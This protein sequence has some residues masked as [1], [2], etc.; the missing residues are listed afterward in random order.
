MSAPC[1]LY[2]L[3][4][5]ADQ[6]LYVGITN[7][8]QRR[9]REHSRT[10][11]W[12]PQVDLRTVLIYQYDCREDACDLEALAIETERPLYNVVHSG[13]AVR[14][15]SHRRQ[16]PP[17]LRP[18]GIRKKRRRPVLPAHALAWTCLLILIGE[19]GGM[20]DMPGHVIGVAS[21][22]AICTTLYILGRNP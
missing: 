4:N 5:R 13:G 19:L 3:Y 6:L 10:K 17:N 7:D 1:Y 2:R 15:L 9:L 20:W 22:L 11:P 14:P 16:K 12:W 18:R 8:P 21:F